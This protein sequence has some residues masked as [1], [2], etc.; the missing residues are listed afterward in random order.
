MTPVPP[1]QS[2]NGGEVPASAEDDAKFLL[3]QKTTQIRK[4]KQIKALIK[5]RNK[6]KSSRNDNPSSLPYNDNHTTLK[7]GGALIDSYK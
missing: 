6:V 5:P 4:R 7:R 2:T 1:H 3:W